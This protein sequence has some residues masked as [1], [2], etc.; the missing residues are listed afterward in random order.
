MQPLGKDLILSEINALVMDIVIEHTH[1]DRRR[2]QKENGISFSRLVSEVNARKI[3]FLKTHFPS[4]TPAT[5]PGRIRLKNIV[6]KN[7]V[8]LGL[9][10][11]RSDGIQINSPDQAT[12]G[13]KWQ[14]LSK[15]KVSPEFFA[16]IIAARG[17][18]SICERR[19]MNLMTRRRFD[20]AAFLEFELLLREISILPFQFYFETHKLSSEVRWRIYQDIMPRARRLVDKLLAIRKTQFER[21]TD[22]DNI[23]L[24]L[25]TLISTCVLLTRPSMVRERE[26]SHFSLRVVL[27]NKTTME[28]AKKLEGAIRNLSKENILIDVEPWS[29]E[30]L[31]TWFD[32]Q[33][34]KNSVLE[35]VQRFG[36]R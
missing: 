7:L 24:E 6:W 1:V 9:V 5:Y 15:K 26:L 36:S 16:A 10:E 11:V 33:F 8:P 19:I 18:L 2:S 14:I 13:K 17:K 21:V 32:T 20:L 3:E 34:H 4:V 22:F 35:K 30:M 28:E 31:Q 29:S 23:I 12:G 27:Q 25:T